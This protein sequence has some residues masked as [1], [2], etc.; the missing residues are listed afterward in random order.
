MKKI[1]LTEN[2][3][4]AN[5]IDSMFCPRH[6]WERN[7]EGF[8]LFLFHGTECRVVFSSAEWFG[9]EFQGFAYIFVPRNGTPSCFLLRGMV[10]DRIPRVC[11][12]FCSIVQ[13]SKHFS[14]LWNGSERNSARTNLLFR[15]FRLPRTNFLVRNCQP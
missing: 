14:P 8:L 3:A 12:Y 13:N 2:P 10:Q 4:P 11:F 6:D 1:C 15:L 9:T 7:S 5:R